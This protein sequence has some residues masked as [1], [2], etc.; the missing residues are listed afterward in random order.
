MDDNELS[1]THDREQTEAAVAQ[2]CE[3]LS[4]HTGNYVI[5]ARTGKGSY[6]RQISGRNCVERIAI[7]SGVFADLA[8]LVSDVALAA[9]RET[10]RLDGE[11]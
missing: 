5:Y 7:A 1:K 9:A 2:A 11:A 10:D 8:M 4:K 6:A 3:L